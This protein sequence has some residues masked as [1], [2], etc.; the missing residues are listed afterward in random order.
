[1][2]ILF[3]GLSITSS[4]GN[5]HATTYRSLCKALHTLGHQVVF[6]EKDVSWY[7]EHRDLVHPEFCQLQLYQEWN[8]GTPILHEAK[9]AD[10]IIVGSY[11]PDAISAIDLITNYVS[12][13]VLFYDIDTPITVAA[14]K[15]GS[16]AY[17]RADQIPEFDAYLSFSGGKLLDI[18]TQEF[19]AKAALP[20]YCSVDQDL[21]Q[22]VRD[23]DRF[24]VDLSYLG[25]YAEDRQPKL[26]HLLNRTACVLQ[27]RS[28]LV[29]GPQYPATDWAPNVRVM[30]H[31]A[32]VD[33][34][35]FYSSARYTLN[36]TRA[37][38]VQ[39]GHSPSVR[40]FEAAA[41]GAAIISDAWPG[42]E[43]FLKPGTEI[44]LA[45]TTEDVLDIIQNTSE[46]ERC[47]VGS[48][49]RNR[50]LTTHTS[51]HRANEFERI[52]ERVINQKATGLFSRTANAF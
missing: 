19:K 11:F 17:L 15:N 7:R 26:L 39:A 6:A 29:A 51:L 27:D 38:M 47:L 36:L 31:V 18:L 37:D 8:E 12:A 9:R 4:W 5:G 3:L 24:R 45:Q 42:L 28:F 34:A 1:M 41:C 40:L 16:C 23:D 30:S 10:V 2:R 21:Y 50:I 32:P 48:R 49:A 44:L 46:E 13:P 14:L 33:H 20:L 35:A 22:S 25:T 52:V 43:Q